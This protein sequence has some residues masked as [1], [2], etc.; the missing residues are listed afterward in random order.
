MN[1]FEYK[2]LLFAL[3]IYLNLSRRY[4]KKFKILTPKF[5]HQVKS[6]PMGSI[7]KSI[8]CFIKFKINQNLEIEFNRDNKYNFFYL[9]MKKLSKNIKYKKIY[10]IFKAIFS[11]YPLRSLSVKGIFVS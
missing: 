1:Y 10:Y 6:T 8:F 3:E 5:R 9:I 7:S 4:N 11:V 2:I